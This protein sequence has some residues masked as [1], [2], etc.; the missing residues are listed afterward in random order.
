L[1]EAMD[2]VPENS[3]EDVRNPFDSSTFIVLDECNETETEDNNISDPNK[4]STPAFIKK[5][6]IHVAFNDR[7]NYDQHR[8]SF[9]RFLKSLKFKSQKNIV[10]KD[11]S[12]I[13]TI[14]VVA[15]KND[16]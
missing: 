3:I 9:L 7:F 13:Y 6:F 11:N 4:S 16:V 2:I 8:E 10:V 1:T 5:P 12:E 14:D 15:D